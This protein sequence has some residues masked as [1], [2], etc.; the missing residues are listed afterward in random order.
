MPGKPNYYTLLADFAITRRK[1][2]HMLLSVDDLHVMSSN[3]LEDIFDYVLDHDR[4]S[5][6]LKTSN[7][8]YLLT[9]NRLPEGAEGMLD[10]EPG[11]IDHQT[12]L[13]IAAGSEIA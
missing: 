4:R 10:A 2:V 5:V 6:I 1:R 3:H 13:D 9:V 11:G 7:K 12:A 8:N